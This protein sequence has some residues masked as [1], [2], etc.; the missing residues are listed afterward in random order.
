MKMAEG[1]YYEVKVAL[2]ALEALEVLE[3]GS[4]SKDCMTTSF[5]R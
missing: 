1:L 2:E 3:E 4:S 5:V